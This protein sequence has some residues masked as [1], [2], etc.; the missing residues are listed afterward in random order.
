MKASPGWDFHFMQ[1]VEDG[2]WYHKYGAST[3]LSYKYTPSSD[4]PWVAEGLDD[5]G[6][7]RNEDNQYV[8]DIYFIT[9][10]KCQETDYSIRV[11]GND[12][13][14]ETCLV[15]GATRGQ[16]ENCTYQYQYSD[17]DTHILTCTECHNIKGS[18][19]PCMYT[20]NRC[21][22]CGHYKISGGIIQSVCV[23]NEK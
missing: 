4:R 22:S 6:Y 5:V 17:H 21:T 14:I 12:K 7:F 10:T 11:C 20:N 23:Q 8:G 13:H 18:A 16:E 3:P 2:S 19:M 9:Y 1:Y 15:C